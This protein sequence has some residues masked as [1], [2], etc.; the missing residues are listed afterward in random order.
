MAS[1]VDCLKKQLALLEDARAQA[2][3]VDS[4]VSFGPQVAA[5]DAASLPESITVVKN[6]DF[7]ELT[8]MKTKRSVTAITACSNARGISFI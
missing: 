8:S 3:N 1:N 7:I 6:S 5:V 4:L 2:D